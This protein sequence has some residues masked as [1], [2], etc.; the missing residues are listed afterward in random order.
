MDDIFLPTFLHGGM[1]GAGMACC[2][3]PANPS[4][5]SEQWGRRSLSFLAP[6]LAFLLYFATEKGGTAL[7]ATVFDIYIP[8]QGRTCS[9]HL[10][11]LACPSLALPCS[12]VAAAA[13]RESLR[14]GCSL[15]LRSFDF[16]L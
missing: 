14:F 12:L 10:P 7:F 5:G 13:C 15:I 1:H 8:E 11:A 4:L 2:Y 9:L 6:Y 16:D 3:L